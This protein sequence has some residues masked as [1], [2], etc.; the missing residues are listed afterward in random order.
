MAIN[1]NLNIDVNDSA[2]SIASLINGTNSGTKRNL[3]GIANFIGALQ[4]GARSFSSGRI[5]I[6]TKAFAVLTVSGTPVADETFVINGVTFTAKASGTAENTFI[7]SANNTTCAK[8]IAAAI[9]ASVT[10]GIANAIVATSADGVITLTAIGDGY[11]ALGFTISESMTGLA[12][13][14][15]FATTTKTANITI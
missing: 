1:V 9:N 13:T 7:L 2:D 8:N 3:Q 12:I 6:T 5:T 10:D 14:S 4:G 15:A 11:S